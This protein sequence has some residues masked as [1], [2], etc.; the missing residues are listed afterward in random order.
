M[1]GLRYKS[2][3]KSQTS[4]A[5][6]ERFCLQTLTIAVFLLLPLVS[7]GQVII[8]EVM[9]DLSGTDSNEWIEVQNVGSQDVDFSTWKLFEGNSNHGLKIFQGNQNLAPNSFA[10]ISDD[11]NA[12][13]AEHAGFTGTI[14]DS[15]F[16][17]S[18]TGETLAIRDSLLLD[19][20]TF[21]YTSDM[22]S[23]GDGTSLQKI[24]NEWKPG[25]PN[26]G[27]VNLVSDQN[28]TTPLS[29]AQTVSIST[30]ST[31]AQE[32]KVESSQPFSVSI[33]KDRLV[34]VGN[35]VM[36]RAE[37]KNQHSYTG[38]SASFS[39]SMG[40]GSQK[41]GQV[42]T[43]NYRY[44]GDYI[45]VL[46]ASRGE[47]SVVSRVLVKVV[48]PEVEMTI[49]PDGSV[50]VVNH[51]KDEINLHRWKIESLDQVFTFPQDTL[52]KGKVSV[53]IPPSALGIIL[54][55]AFPIK[56]KNPL[57]LAYVYTGK[58]KIIVEEVS[59]SS[60]VTV[61][62]ESVPGSKENPKIL[63]ADKI[64]NTAASEADNSTGSIVEEI[65]PQPA[66]VSQAFEVSKPK[67][68]W[69]GFV[70]FFKRLFD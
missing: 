36:F 35:E 13:L 41:N 57:G 50:K 24:S 60:D 25:I 70:N 3:I 53:V 66:A 16:S 61:K 26:P 23:N 2:N 68:F 52:I 37:V 22:G 6:R 10:I 56:I 34:A 27:R 58:E 14:F 8:T 20:D 31:S 62:P 46:N 12:F 69:I 18:N 64:E 33:G 15:S 38:R 55:P 51:G 7:Y 40:D 45:V 11:P 47:D 63:L 1:P 17:L 9:Y 28:N 48:E 42:I 4:H 30:Y 19:I 29:N 59:K 67:G 21:S 43:Y 32:S 54:T 5:P 49:L 44:P 39:W 65:S